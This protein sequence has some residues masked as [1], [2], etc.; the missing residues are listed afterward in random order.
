M[1]RQ[2]LFADAPW[3]VEETDSRSRI[4]WRP[5][6]ARM[7]ATLY[8]LGPGYDGDRVHM[9]YGA[10]EMFFVLSGRIVVRNLEG[11]EELAPGDFLFCPEGRAG[12]HARAGQDPGHERRELSR[13]R[14]LPGGRLRVGRD[15]S[16]GASTRRGSGHHRPLR[17]P[18]RSAGS[19]SRL[20]RS[21]FPSSFQPR[22]IRD[23]ES[24]GMSIN[25]IILLNGILD[26]GVVLAVAAT[27]LIPFMVDRRRHDAALY[28]FAAP[29][30]EDLAA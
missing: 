8:E 25:H 28:A 10:E 26:L 14:R 21:A 12:L 16:S 1:N 2:N 9:H 6:D 7:G 15:A 5:D 13:C 30:R 29:L 20:I 27:M 19:A 23:G 24:G 3:D 4:F 11:E 18:T 22:H 17:L